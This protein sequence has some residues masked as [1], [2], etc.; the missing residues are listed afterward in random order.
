MSYYP[1]LPPADQSASPRPP[2]A[3]AGAVP[4]YVSPYGPPQ[5]PGYCAPPAAP[6]PAAAPLPQP[7][8]HRYPPPVHQPSA[9]YAPPVHQYSQGPQQQQQ[10]Q[11]QQTPYAPQYSQFPQQQQQQQQA[12]YAPQQQH[13]AYA[14]QQQQ[15]Q[16]A[17][18]QQQQ[19]AYAPQAQPQ[20]AYAPQPLQ[21][22]QQ[23][24]YVYPTPP[25][26]YGAVLP[27]APHAMRAPGPVPVLSVGPV[28]VVVPAPVCGGGAMVG[29]PQHDAMRLRYAVQG[30]GT[31]EAELID[32]VSR[33]SREQ[34][35]AVAQA[36]EAM[37]HK[38]LRSDISGDTSFNFRTILL[39]KLKPI[40]EYLADTVYEAV[41]GLGTKEL[42]LIDVLTQVT[43]QEK[44]MMIAAW[45]S[46]YSHEGP[47]AARVRRDTSFNFMKTLVRCI[48]TNRMPPGTV[49]QSR[50]Q[51]DAE[52]LYHAGEGRWGTTD[53]V[54]VEILT[55][56]SAE[57]MQ[58]V[59]L[60]YRQHNGHGIEKA[61]EKETSGDYMRALLALATPRGQYVARRIHE[62]VC[63]LGTNDSLLIRMFLM[64][65]YYLPEVTHWY[66]M[67]Y[68]ESLEH[69]VRDD[70][71]GHYKKF[72]VALMRK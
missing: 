56:S 5:S 31:D 40:G 21:P 2:Y 28:T 46:K 36:Y 67:F 62:A 41:R 19:M 47:M 69:A 55:R 24:Q 35:Q 12:P 58:A 70:T 27:P 8:Q 37:Y 57:H 59:S 42:S 18:G 43:P 25:Q 68:G 3:P 52:E 44:A 53:H 20:M 26:A 49:D 54:F 17:Y 38:S 23:Q 15:P 32:I 9:P 16:M 39:G 48:E 4:S 10:Q 14:Q 45:N 63:G 13:M 61:I 66:K 51:F 71:S 60:V 34:L 30:L 50:V 22:Q 7:L 33:R 64:N 72:L 1:T 29:T 11:Q 65:E 6:A